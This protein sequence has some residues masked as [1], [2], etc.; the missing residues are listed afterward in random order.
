MAHSLVYRKFVRALYQSCLP[1]MYCLDTCTLLAQTT[2]IDPDPLHCVA[3]PARLIGMQRALRILALLLLV[4]GCATPS[5]PDPTASEP[6]EPLALAPAVDTAALGVLYHSP[7]R[8]CG[9]VALGP[10]VV[11]SAAHCVAYDEATHTI[12]S[13][14][15]GTPGPWYV[16]Q[17]TFDAARATDT[18]VDPLPTTVLWTDT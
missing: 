3:T 5:A 9:A 1:H 15:A 4:V 8:T 13:K 14:P 10:R 11:L 6:T 16:P 12:L 7:T 18:Y 2:K 17:P